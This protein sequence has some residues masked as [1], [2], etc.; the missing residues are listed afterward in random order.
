MPSAVSPNPRAA[1]PSADDI[2][3]LFN[4]DD[5]VDDFLKDLPLDKDAQHD[6]TT[7]TA[8][9]A[10]KNI[11]E[12]IIVR[13]KRKPVPKLDEQL[14]LSDKGLSKL[15]KITRSRIKFR[16]KGHEFSDMSMLLDTYQLWLDELYP[17]AKFR[18][19][20]SMVEKVGHSKA[21]QVRR[22]AWL[23]D[24]KPTARDPSPEKD[25]DVVMSG[26]LP[27]RDAGDGEQRS[28]SPIF[29]ADAIAGGQSKAREGTE[30]S[31]DAPDDDE[32]DALLAEDT[33]LTKTAAPQLPKQRAPFE[34]DEDEDE[35]DALLAE[36]NSVAFG[37]SK[38]QQETQQSQR[39][40]STSNERTVNDFADEEEAMADM[41]MW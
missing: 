35:M 3:K 6:T 18:D 12:E 9:E 29:P 22:R 10:P 39:A 13:K 4:Y 21:M 41:D 5:A 1:T 25:D 38:S 24:T 30:H 34:E 28:E 8:Q 32:L 23:D 20:L 37:G 36:E 14:L 26:A 11:D 2:E 17:R 27:N 16:G 31:E 15:R 19:A 7:T 40:G 33:A